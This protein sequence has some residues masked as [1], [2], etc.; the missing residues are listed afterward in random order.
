MFHMR[1]RVFLLGC[2]AM[3]LDKSFPVSREHIMSI[4]RITA[5]PAQ[6]CWFQLVLLGTH[7]TPEREA[8][9]LF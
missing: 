5:S 6:T 9:I 8:D 7:F 4:F 2:N 3:W 1:S